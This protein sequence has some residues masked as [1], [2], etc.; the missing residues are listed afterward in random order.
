M[1]HGA[2]PL[3]VKVA[4]VWMRKHPD[5]T[6]LDEAI[7]AGNLAL[8]DA[9]AKWHERMG[10]FDRYASSA[11]YKAITKDVRASQRFSNKFQQLPEDWGDD[12]EE[13]MG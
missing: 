5:E 9:A 8:C 11:I 12:V 3:V 6:T 4:K 1:P 10:P 13:D 7:S 2:V